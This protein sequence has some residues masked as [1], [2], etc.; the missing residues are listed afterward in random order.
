MEKA[1]LDSVKQSADQIL[2]EASFSPEDE[3][4]EVLLVVFDAIYKM[5]MTQVSDM[6]DAVKQK[7]VKLP[8]GDKAWRYTRRVIKTKGKDDDEYRWPRA[9][10]NERA[11]FLSPQERI[12]ITI[13]KRK[14]GTLCLIPLNRDIADVIKIKEY[15]D[16]QGYGR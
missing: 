1:K 8:N 15:F 12:G 6:G 14:D 10:E 4:Y 9:E 7:F 16:K 3:G 13:A 2:K 11:S 5:P